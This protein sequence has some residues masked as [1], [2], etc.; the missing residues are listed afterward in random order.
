[1][2]WKHESLAIV[3]WWEIAK[4][5][6]LKPELLWQVQRVQCCVSLLAYAAS[7]FSDA[8]CAE[9]GNLPPQIT[10]GRQRR[11]ARGELATDQQAAGM[12]LMGR[13]L[14][15][16]RWCSIFLRCFLWLR[17]FC[18]RGVVEIS[19]G[20]HHQGKWVLPSVWV[21][22]DPVWVAWQHGKMTSALRRQRRF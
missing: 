15:K 21:R 13:Q 2:C 16:L 10:D 8:R 18:S 1:M 20:C 3:L 17:K 14:A 4:P 5:V 9:N 11:R 7:N 19:F 6:I 22:A 12:P